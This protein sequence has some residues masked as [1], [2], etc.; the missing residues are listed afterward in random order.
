MASTLVVLWDSWACKWFLCFFSWSFPSVCL[1]QLR[2]DR[3]VLGYI[4]FWYILLLS[5]SS[6]LFSLMTERKGVD[7]WEERWKVGRGRRRGRG[8]HNQDILCKNQSISVRRGEVVPETRLIHKGTSWIAIPCELGSTLRS[9]YWSS[10]TS[11]VTQQ[12]KK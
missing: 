9:N 1:V 10:E 7:G 3:F 11:W 5:F 6:L 8:N 2:W 4:L 12:E